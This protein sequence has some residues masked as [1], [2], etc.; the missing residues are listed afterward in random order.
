MCLH[1]YMCTPSESKMNTNIRPHDYFQTNV[2]LYPFYPVFME[3]DGTLN[4]GNK[5]T[6]NRVTAVWR[7]EEVWKRGTPHTR[8]V[9]C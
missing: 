7:L 6:Q 8:W 3:T 1:T 9:A 5:T 2:C 4:I